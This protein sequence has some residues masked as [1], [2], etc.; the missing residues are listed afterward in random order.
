MTRKI[1]TYELAQGLLSYVLL[2]AVAIGATFTFEYFSLISA[3]DLSGWGANNLPNI[4]TIAWGVAVV[5]LVSKAWG[6][7]VAFGRYYRKTLSQKL[8]ALAYKLER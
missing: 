1:D 8:H 6:S 7:W 2:F 4:I 3:N 5:A